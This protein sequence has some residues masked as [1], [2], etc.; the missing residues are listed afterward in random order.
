[1]SD[2]GTCR[3]A[4]LAALA[5]G[6]AACS[7]TAVV[8]T[9]QSF[10]RPGHTSLVCFDVTTSPP[11]AVPLARCAP[12][13]PGSSTLP[14]GLDLHALVLQSRRGEIA[15]VELRTNKILDT[16]KTIPGYT[17]IE[18][19]ALP[20]DLVSSRGLT[21]GAPITTYVAN[22][23]TEDVW[24]FA[25]SA[26]RAPATTGRA[27]S[28]QEPLGAAPSAVALTPDE[29]FL[30]VALPTL[31]VL[32]Q[33]PVLADGRLDHANAR[34]IPLAADVP[35]PLAPEPETPLYHRECT[36]ATLALPT[37][38]PAREARSD[39]TAPY[40]VALLIDEEAHELLVGDA[41]LPVV[42]R[43]GIDG[44]AG[45][46][47]E[48]PPLAIG[49]PVHDLALTPRVP[50]T[51]DGMVADRRY[52]YALDDTGAVAVMDLSD[53]V[54]FPNGQP[55][56]IEIPTARAQDR[57]TFAAPAT[58]LTMV[59]S[60]DYAPASPNPF[61]VGEN[62]TPE[63]NGPARLHGVFLVASLTDGTVRFVDVYDR[64]A[65]CR[66]SAGL[67]SE[68]T[69]AASNDG[70]VYI[71]RHRPRI[72]VTVST[73]VGVIGS[74]TLSV[75][76]VPYA[77][78]EDGQ[79]ASSSVPDLAPL[80][81]CA[82][83]GPSFVQ[84]YPRTD[85][86][87]LVCA[88]GDP[89]AATQE[90][91]VATYE[92]TIFSGAAGRFDGSS[93]I[94]GETDFCRAG[95]LGTVGAAALVTGLPG[96]AQGDQLVL[97]GDLPPGTL[98]SH[99]DC[100][101]LVATDPATAARVVVAF[102]VVDADDAG[103]LTIGPITLDGAYTRDFVATCFPEL[104]TFDVRSRGSWV[105]RGA[106]SGLVRA[107]ASALGS[108]RVPTPAPENAGLGFRAYSNTPFVSRALAFQISED[109]AVPATRGMTLTLDLGGLPAG[110]GIDLTPG[111]LSGSIPV[112]LFYSSV[113]NKLYAVDAGRA[114][115][116]RISIDNVSTERFFQ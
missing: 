31:G 104:V 84:A 6:S 113:E 62:L 33:F 81:D 51:V 50:S 44:L 99:P 52:L 40:P 91:W 109:P 75:A 74:P 19:G 78:G 18:A 87:A 12:T 15:V 27:E 29:R 41:A 49:T 88:V 48:A 115:L 85:A 3:A 45:L 58:S 9:P 111:S 1:M 23:G 26:F 7:Q 94:A 98:H 112:E 56:S 28:Q 14:T 101:G 105:V 69:T 8:T 93:F 43:F 100:A 83:L 21:A 34:D 102:E 76:A 116:A 97:T 82:P 66:G 57:I 77:I 5:V 36:T 92:G 47:A 73:E 11:V 53:P 13:E 17:F 61:C 108:C 46:G 68:T 22:A 54:A 95:V 106:Y 10:D 63:S 60:R 25:A 65:A 89:W 103:V 38:A 55:L 90:R 110:L 79:A 114:A 70:V 59:A 64:D 24:V 4:L 80:T 20:V 96:V 71:R 107:Q 72:G 32:R 2:A 16:N 67:C 35:E 42:H 30:I 86:A 37:S 39:G